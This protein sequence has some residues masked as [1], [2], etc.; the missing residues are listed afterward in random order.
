MSIAHGCSIA[1]A[2]WALGMLIAPL[3]DV[4]GENGALWLRASGVALGLTLVG[5]GRALSRAPR[6]PEVASSGASQA[7]GQLVLLLIVASILRAIGLNTGM[8]FDEIAT[9]VEF[10]RLTPADV[11]ST[12]TSTNNHIFFTL[13]ANAS[14]SLFGESPWA[15]RL[16][17]ALFGIASLAALWWMAH[18][19]APQREARLASWLVALS[20]HHVWF[21][22]NA[23]GYT[24]ILLCSWL[25]TALFLRA[26]R[27]GR[28]ELWLAYAATLGL[29]M[30]TH[31]SAVFIF[32]V[33]GFVYLVDESLRWRRAQASAN[34]ESRPSFDAWPLLG[35]A[36]GLL[37]VVQLYAALIPQLF[38]TFSAQSGVGRNHV[39]NPLWTNPFWTA[40]EIVRG[41]HLGPASMG[42][43]AAGLAIAGI[44]FTSIA[45]REPLHALLIALPPVLTLLVLISIGFNIWPRYFLVSLGFG[46]IV[47]LRG[48]FASAETLARLHNTPSTLRDPLRVATAAGLL[49]IVF[50]TTTLVRNYRFPKQDYGGARDFI[51]QVREGDEL[52]LTTGLATYPYETYYALDSGWEKFS[53]ISQLEE[54]QAD[55]E[56]VWV[57]YSFPTHLRTTAPDLFARIQRDFETVRSFPGTLG[58]GDVHV[59]RSRRSPDSTSR[60]P[61]RLEFANTGNGASPSGGGWTAQLQTR[62]ST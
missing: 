54:F 41:L 42:V 43:A 15:L 51:A 38:D 35:F 46:V 61:S 26:R 20:Y 56:N 47:G 48:L 30:Y 31:L 39:P 53:S 13:L 10:V 3:D 5:A 50:S 33:H 62:T 44:G 52:V 55:H 23:R 59:L 32:A 1:G 28:K 21:S 34:L 6:S 14:V 18:E 25:A 24:G 29:G 12:Y 7:T 22:Q 60:L 11:V 57:I 19:L 9:L 45:R 4:G 17:A 8:W 16:P 37:L 2:L 40:L 58:D 36:L 49:L 27:G